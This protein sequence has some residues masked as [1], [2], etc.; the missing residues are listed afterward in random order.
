M[1]KDAIAQSSEQ[2]PPAR[3]NIKPRKLSPH[4][5]PKERALWVWA[6]V[7]NLDVFLQDCYDYYLQNG[8]HCIVIKKL[9]DVLTLVFVVY[10]STFLGYCVDYLKLGSLHKL[11]EVQYDQCFKTRLHGWSLFF[12]N[13]FVIAVALRCLHFWFIEL[14]RLREMQ[15][16]FEHL[17]E[18]DELELQVVSWQLIM[19]RL[20]RLRDTNVN[21]VLN[22]DLN[23]KTRLTA[24][25]VANRIMRKENYLVAL[26]NKQILSFELRFPILSLLTSVQYL[27]KT[28]EWTVNL[29]VMG[30]VFD[31]QGQFDTAFLKES[32][33]AHLADTLRRRFY[34]CGTFG[35]FV[36]PL[37]AAYFVVVN[38]LR[39]F[40]EFRSDPALIGARGFSP[41]AEWRFREYNELYHFFQKRLFYAQAP[42]TEYLAQ[43]PKERTNLIMKFVSFISGALVTVLI[44]LLVLDPD[45]LITFEITENRSV[46]FYIGIL[47]TIW[48][49]SHG[50]ASDTTMQNRIFDPEK[51]LRAVA[52]HTHYLPSSWEGRFHTESV[53]NEVATLFPL[54][55]VMLAREFL[56]LIFVPFVFWFA[57]PNCAER[58]VDFF[59]ENTVHIEGLG[60]VC[61]AAMFEV[62]QEVKKKKKKED[63]KML[64]SYLHFVES[65]ADQDED[66]RSLKPELE[67]LYVM[68]PQLGRID[69]GGERGAL[70]ILGDFYNQRGRV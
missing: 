27:T 57:L 7:E 45:L 68:N 30:L 66:S 70:G 20:V 67:G 61:V 25:D 53:K 41:F 23:S 58:V 28:L 17:L 11:R 55:L 1:K 5:S 19:R 52:A 18:I 37:L 63:N 35:I 59:R 65:Y 33:R 62:E 13:V 64:K 10:L 26:Y 8:L 9:T 44:L 56:G 22:T 43:F 48:A 47:G 24:H 21:G 51:S 4:L 36:A 2:V 34:V 16:F 40:Y 54:K 15:Q 42:A 46:L 12:L 3:N 6:N 69:E 50:A 60:H 39:F 29:C 38:F 32:N 14:P 31:R 49:A